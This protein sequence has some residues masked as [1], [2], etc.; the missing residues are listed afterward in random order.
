MEDLFS[1]VSC[2]ESRTPSVEDE[3]DDDNSHV[4]ADMFASEQAPCQVL[5]DNLND[6]PDMTKLTLTPNAAY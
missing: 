1:S 6:Y 2:L 4:L 5:N 3:V